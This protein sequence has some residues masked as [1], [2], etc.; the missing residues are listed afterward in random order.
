MAC[1]V[2]NALPRALLPRE[3]IDG[4]TAG[5][6]P[7]C[8]AGANGR[9]HYF[10]VVIALPDFS[11]QAVFTNFDDGPAIVRIRTLNKEQDG[12]AGR[13]APDSLSQ[14]QQKQGCVFKKAAGR[15]V[16]TVLFHSGMPANCRTFIMP[17]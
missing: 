8:R 1:S 12:G 2:R 13:H 6:V 10:R 3:K 16:Q 4:G 11:G 7:G 14:R 9:F 5:Q 15:D 17:A